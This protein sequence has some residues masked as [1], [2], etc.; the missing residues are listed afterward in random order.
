MITEKPP[1][2]IEGKNNPAYSKWYE[3]TETGKAVRR[4]AN[5]RKFVKSVETGAYAY[6]ILNGMTDKEIYG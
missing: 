6:K 3:G 4:R 5:H 2:K 1:R